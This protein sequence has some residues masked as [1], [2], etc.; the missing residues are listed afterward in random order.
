MRITEL[1]A[2]LYRF[3][4]PSLRNLEFTYPYMHDG[5]IQTLDD[6]L[7]HYSN[8]QLHVQNEKIIPLL[9]EEK[10]AIMAFLKTLTD[11]QFI[12]NL[13]FSEPR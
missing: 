2:D 6:V 10:E 1:P 9:P 11:Y 13:K 7:N 3:K 8:S 5:K 4:V 12:S